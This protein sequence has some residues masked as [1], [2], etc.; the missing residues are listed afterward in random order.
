[1]KGKWV[2]FGVLIVLAAGLASVNC[3]RDQELVSIQIQPDTETFGASD[4]QVSA[5]A[6]AQVQL[7]A[8]GSYIHP[9][10]TKDITNQV[11]WSSNTPQMVTVNSSGLITVTGDACGGT[12]ISATVDT[13]KSSGGISSSGALVTGYMTAN[14]VCFTSSGGGSGNPALTLTFLGS[15][16]GTVSSSPGGLSCSS[17][18]ACVT[19]AFSSGTPVTLTASPNGSSTFGGW[20]GC[21]S[22]TSTNVC[23][24]TV[25]ANANLTVTFN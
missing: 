22:P 17:P 9:P 5:N 4:I 11:T 6:G 1:M 18:A 21:P 2:S 10:V 20:S 25:A 24:F 13:N 8:L 3:G 12:L 16:S 23:A 19:Q 7:R 15:G 14:V